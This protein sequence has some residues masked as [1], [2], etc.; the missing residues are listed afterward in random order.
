MKDASPLHASSTS[1]PHRRWSI[2][3]RLAVWYVLSASVMLC[4]TTAFLYWTLAVDFRDEEDNFL[5]DE[6]ETLTAILREHPGDIEPLK[7]EVE[8]EGAA[9]R[10]GKY[11]A[12]ILDPDKRII[13]QSSGMESAVPAIDTFP[14]PSQT[15]DKLDTEKWLSSVG[16]TFLLVTS[17]AHLPVANNGN[18]IIQVALDI[19]GPEAKLAKYR[20]WLAIVLCLGVIGS[21]AAGVIIARRGMRPLKA[22]T[23]AAHKIT[24]EQLNARIAPARWPEELT[25]LATEFDKMLERLEESFKRLSQ[26]SPDLAHELRTPINNLMGEAEV[27][28]SRSRTPEEYRH[29]LESALEE[30]GRFARMIDSLLFLARADNA[31]TKLQRSPF[32]V[33]TEVQGVLDFYSALAE[34]QQI[35][36]KRQGTGTLNA[37]RILFRRALTNLVSNALH[38]TPAGGTVTVAVATPAQKT[39]EI[40]VTDTGCGISQEHVSKVFDR[41]YRIDPA[42]ARST[43]GL[44]LGLSIVKSIMT[45]HGGEVSLQSAPSMGT[46]V[47]LRFP[48]A[49]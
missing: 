27:A 49:V 16:K 2:T 38:Y 25:L 20:R 35:Q 4:L 7:V 36:V 31:E 47:T 14:L 1:A 44:G 30:Y 3:L 21:A 34:E 8:L 43:E 12:R 26:F 22:I 6:I 48:R 42:R 23:D 46:T 13:I 15:V 39:V 11:Y 32:D 9:R 17:E 5:T 18:P 28:L 33:A 40:R 45:L 37:D 29:V 24:A 41:F 10:Y 19:T